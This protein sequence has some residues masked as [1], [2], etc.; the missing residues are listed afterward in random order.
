MIEIISDCVGC[1]KPVCNGGC[2]LAKETETW[3]CDN[4]GC[5]IESGEKM[6]YREGTQLCEKCLIDITLDTTDHATK[7]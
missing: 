5:Y 1:P 7:E 2:E 3:T 6:Y 4:C